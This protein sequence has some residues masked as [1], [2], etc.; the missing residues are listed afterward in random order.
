MAFKRASEH[1]QAL[2]MRGII[3]ANRRHRHRAGEELELRFSRRYF[4]PDNIG[5]ARRLIH[6]KIRRI[7]QNRRIS[8]GAHFKPIAGIHHSGTNEITIRS[9][10]REG[11]LRAEG[12]IFGLSL[13]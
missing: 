2:A 10:G 8:H 1:Q 4:E 3:N 9:P 5:N 7:Y 6:S 12:D 13:D 11:D